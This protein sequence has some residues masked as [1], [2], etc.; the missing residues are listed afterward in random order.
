MKEKLDVIQQ[1]QVVGCHL[2]E[3]HR[4]SSSIHQGGSK[5]YMS[6]L[7]VVY[8]KVPLDLPVLYID[9]IRLKCI[10]IIRY[11]DFEVISLRKRKITITFI[12]SLM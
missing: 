9:D 5:G 10:R 1:V 3:Y 2:P 12:R 6:A 7:R 8:G 11:P 4:G